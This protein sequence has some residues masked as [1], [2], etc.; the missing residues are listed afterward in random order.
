MKKCWALLLIAVLLTG[1][2]GTAAAEETVYHDVTM[3]WN[4]G[5]TED[6]ILQAKDG[7]RIKQPETPENEELLFTGWYTDEE[8]TSK[9]IFSTKIT[10]D[11][12][13]YA[14]WLPVTVFEAEGMMMDDMSG[15]GYSGASYDYSMIVK[16]RFGAGASG[17]AFVSYL[18]ARYDNNAYNTTLEFHIDASEAASGVHLV[19]RLSAEYEDITINGD[20]YEVL[21]NGAKIG[22]DDITFTG[23]ADATANGSVLPFQDFEISADVV[24]MEG[25]NIIQLRTAN[26]RKQGAGGTMNSTAPM[27]DCI[28]LAVSGVELTWTDGWTADD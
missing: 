16:D 18:Y 9:F 10:D 17:G 11:M 27:V 3:H 23:A 12:D 14:Q 1:C 2:L 20:M 8:L 28:K 5:A 25:E 7:G 24:L 19:L 4:D 21:V 26:S 6:L 13:L 22:F 15:P